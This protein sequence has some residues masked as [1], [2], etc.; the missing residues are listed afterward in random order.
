MTDSRMFWLIFCIVLIGLFYLLSP[1]IT[2]FLVSALLAYLGDPVT[3]RLEKLHLS[4]SISVIIVFMFFTLMAALIVIILI[5]TIDN[6]F[7]LLS[8]KLPDYIGWIKTTVIPK[9][10]TLIPINANNLNIEGIQETI[11]NN[12]GNAANAFQQILSGL[13]KPANFIVTTATYLFLIPV[14]TFYLLRDWDILIAKLNELV[15]RQYYDTVQVLTSRS[16]EVLA[17]FLRGQLFVMLALG[18]IYATGLSIIGLDMA[19][20]IGL[21]SG[22]VSF[23]PYLGLIVGI[24]I[25]GLMAVIQFQDLM[26]PFQVII[27]FTV[28][29]M[30]E[31]VFLTPMFVG[32]RTGLHPVAVIFSVLAGGQLFG[33]MGILL[34]LPAAAVINVFLS[35]F[36]EHYL[37]S[38]IYCDDEEKT[39]DEKTI[40]M[41]EEATEKSL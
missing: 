21:F 35:Y 14:V 10:N 17:G 2:P 28:A 33:F 15:P 41:S 19:I 23:V 32:D 20:I 3:D 4:R 40:I 1:I 16:D 9:I 37:Q 30:I 13:R 26:H 39:D 36:K 34:A 5:P 29:Q 11:S 18:I 7:H 22:F 25:A 12:L 27:V 8:T 24:A 38:D 31:G 6:Q